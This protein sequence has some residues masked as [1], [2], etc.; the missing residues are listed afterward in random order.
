M[1]CA[2]DLSVNVISCAWVTLENIHT[3]HRQVHTNINTLN[4]E[5]RGEASWSP[6]TETQSHSYLTV[7]F[8]SSSPPLEVFLKSSLWF[9]LS[10][11]SLCMKRLGDAEELFI[12]TRNTDIEKCLI[13][14]WLDAVPKQTTHQKQQQTEKQGKSA[15]L[16]FPDDCPIVSFCVWNKQRK[17]R[18]CC[19]FPALKKKTRQS[20]LIGRF[21]HPI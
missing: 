5:R 1:Y 18:F 15:T 21:Q 7:R 8:L 17:P 13:D 12:S 2:V 3:S 4:A 11:F 10:H 16:S 9:L 19:V 20:F 6:W 14:M